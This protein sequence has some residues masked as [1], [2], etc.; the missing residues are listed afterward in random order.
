MRGDL[1]LP[2]AARAPV[3]RLA[4]ALALLA[5]TGGCHVTTTTDVTRPG[6]LDRRVLADRPVAL[7]PTL[8]LTPAGA[9]RFV[10][11]LT[12][13]TEETVRTV[14]TIEIEERPNLATFVVGVIATAVGGVLLVRGLAESAPGNLTTYVGI[15][16][17]GAG[18]P[19]AIGPWLGTTVALR[20]GPD[21]AP[22]RRAGPSEACGERPLAARSAVLEIAGRQVYGT[23]DADGT[24]ALAAFALVDAYAGEAPAPWQVTA[25]VDTGAGPRT[26]TTVI[27]G[28]ALAAAAPAF[29]AHAPF[30]AT[31]APL[32]LVPDLR[33]G[34]L[35]ASLTTTASG[36]ALRIVLPLVV[37]KG[38]TWGL[39]GV[40]TASTPAV[41]GRVLYVGH[42]GPGAVTAPELLVPLSA[43]AAAELRG[44]TLELA[45]E[46]RDAHGTAPVTPVR[47]KGAV[48]GD[49][50]R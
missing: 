22:V 3:R 25:H 15:T 20:P 27:E 48:L 40:I 8:V 5:A 17:L 47:F 4:A 18:L 12:C 21:T 43:A 26:L 38:E 49:A 13:P 31:I 24:F 46:L 39:R 37:G 42:L 30:D 9:L 29:L 1:V 16:G 44:S 7:P 35:R 36:P 33:P 11:P 6:A 28:G 10:E 14:T 41:D 50:P 19:L 23:I 34:L 2:P 32:R 45:I